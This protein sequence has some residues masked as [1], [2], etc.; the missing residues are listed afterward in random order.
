[1]AA[2]ASEPEKPVRDATIQ[3]SRAG[4]RDDDVRYGQWKIGWHF[5]DELGMLL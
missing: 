2:L 3:Q 1:M 4:A 5:G